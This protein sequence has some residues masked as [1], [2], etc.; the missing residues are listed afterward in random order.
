VAGAAAWI[1]VTD[2]LFLRWFPNPVELVQWSSFKGWAF[3]GA[4]GLGLHLLLRLVF[5][6]QRRDASAARHAESRHRALVESSPDGILVQM[7]EA[8][9]YANPAALRLFGAASADD[10]LGRQ[11][12]DL[13]DPGEHPA[14]LELVRRATVEKGYPPAGIRLLRRLDGGTFRASVSVA[15]LPH[16]GP[17]ALEVTVHDVTEPWRLQAELE[18][19]NRALRLLSAGAEALVRAPGE[20]QLLADICRAAVEHGGFRLAF[21]A[22]A[23]QDEARTLRIAAHHGPGAGYLAGFPHLCWAEDAPGGRGPAGTAVR[24][25]RPVVVDDMAAEPAFAPWLE[26]ARTHGLVGVAALPLSAAGERLGVLALYAGQTGAF[27]AAVLRFL[28]QLAD[29]LAFGLASLRARALLEGLLDNAPTAVYVMGLDGR[30]LRANRAWEEASGLPRG[31]ALGR[32]PEAFG[33]AVGARLRATNDQVVRSQSP[34]RF[35][36]T[37]DGADGLRTHD[38]VKFPVRD[39]AGRVTAVGAISVEIT[40]R[41]RAEEQ[42]RFQARL[43]E[44]VADAVIAVDGERRITYANAAAARRYAPEGTDPASL[45]GRPFL[46]VA[47]FRFVDP[48]QAA[49]AEQAIDTGGVWRGE[50]EHQRRHDGQLLQVEAT[51][52][53]L[54]DETGQAG[55]M[56]GVFRDLSAQKQAE[57]R[58]RE[59]RQQLRAL[60]ARLQTV[61]EEEKTRIA[62]DL[63]D[64]LG[65]LLTGLKLELRGVERQIGDTALP[66]W[67]AGLLDRVVAAS[68]LTDQT[69]AAVQR[70]AADLRPVSLD[71]LGLGAALGLEAR[72][73]QERTGIPCATSLPEDL[74]TTPPEVATALYRIAQEALTNVARHA[75][76]RHVDLTL[77]S[78]PEGLSLR[79]RDD[80]RG[81]GPQDRG[82]RALG[83]LGMRERAV[84]LGGEVRFEELAGGGTCVT[85][86]VPLAAPAGGAAGGAP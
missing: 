84:S 13:V 23:E 52:C 85:A 66:P 79:V 63:H 4:S 5:S 11:A 48:A 58:E 83:L 70:I 31:E 10:L 24:S 26:A 2:A 17:R 74:P 62:R 44:L 82:A 61:R 41:R 25:G 71:R 77:A 18:Q 78:G 64:D 42:A 37:V 72:R 7:G 57:R 20:E 32:L 8:I 81:L 14:L 19:V 51:I 76:A 45:R 67:A 86:L 60:A 59:S 39:P 55:G 73:F 27:D 3:V 33:A 65:Q 9:A 47:G 12:L 15:P 35:E 6:R 38:V 21:V 56:F 30:L 69:V 22:L 54:A 1:G 34:V 40:A 50:L 29:D 28:Q 75:G 36:T 80:G 16:Q 46:E 68:E 43:L 53:G 49:L